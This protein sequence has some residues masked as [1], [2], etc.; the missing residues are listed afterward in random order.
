MTGIF[1]AEWFK[2]R[3][4][5]A[6]LVIGATWLVLVAVL[7]YVLPYLVFKHPPRSLE[8]ARG[9]DQSA[10]LANLLPQNLVHWFVPGLNSLGGTL[11][12][13]LAA[14]VGGSEYGWSTLKTILTQRPGRLTVLAGKL[15][16]LGLLLMLFVVLGYLVAAI[17]SIIV[18]LLEHTALAWPGAAGIVES[19]GA[20]LLIFAA[21]AAL[22]LGLAI[23]V[24]GTEMAIGLSLVYGL[25]VDGLI[26]IF[27][28]VSD[29]AKSISQGLLGA[30]ATALAD[31][32]RASSA[33]R[34]AYGGASQ[35]IAG[36]GQAS[37]VLAV[38][39]VGFVILAAIALQ[40]R[41]V[42]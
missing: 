37:M 8:R 31:T 1:R 20:M 32:F 26:T 19:A 28:S 7:G 17:A 9:F 40:R 21:W 11:V 14:L 23:L 36:A 29:L 12:T 4:R 3:R 41:D 38:Y 30:N 10:E 6:T 35:V 34:S 42:T 39:V 24:R 16:A 27:S 2:L 13:I 5:P 33:V 18:A 25:V 22:G 15:L